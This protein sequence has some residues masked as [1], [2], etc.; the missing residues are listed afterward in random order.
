MVDLSSDLELPADVE[1]DI[2]VYMCLSARQ[3]DEKELVQR[4]GTKRR[5]GTGTENERRRNRLRK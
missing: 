4:A 3:A 1:D 2:N 5:W